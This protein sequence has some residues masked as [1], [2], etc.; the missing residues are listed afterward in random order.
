M[1]LFTPTVLVLA[2][3]S[4]TVQQQCDQPLVNSVVDFVIEQA[5]HKYSRTY[6]LP[7]ISAPFFMNRGIFE[8]SSG[9]IAG[10]NTM[11][12]IDNLDLKFNNQTMLIGLQVQF[13][14][15]VV[16]Y[17]K[18]KIRAFGVES[19]GNFETSIADNLIR[20]E[21][22]MKNHSICFFDV[23]KVKLLR[24][25]EFRVDLNSGCKLCNKLGSWVT[26]KMLNIFEKHV[27]SLVEAKL[28]LVL[29]KALDPSEHS[30]VCK[31]KYLK[32]NLV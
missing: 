23:N 22:T 10:L 8:L 11:R 4:W 32:A 1:F 19:L 6:D 28:D 15:L 24:L 3:I 31:N 17:K 16:S 25:G 21:A 12:R 30:L 2:L 29:Q 26:T 9:S 20:V 13:T 18:Y 7:N 14:N 27:T 5:L